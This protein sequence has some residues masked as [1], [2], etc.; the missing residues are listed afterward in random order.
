[1]EWNNTIIECVTN[2]N[3]NNYVTHMSVISAEVLLNAKYH[4]TL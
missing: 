2:L 4:E 3:T 1:M